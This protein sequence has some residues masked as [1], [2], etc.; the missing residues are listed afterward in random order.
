MTITYKLNEAA[1]VTY[2]LKGRSGRTVKRSRP[3]SRQVLLHGQKNLKADEYTGTLTLR[4][5]FDKKAT[6]K[7]SS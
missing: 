4:D 5:D 7:N 2:K 6:P 3:R 1:T